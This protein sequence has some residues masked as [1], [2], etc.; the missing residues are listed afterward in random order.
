MGSTEAS[1][2]ECHTGMMW[3]AWMLFM[4]QVSATL[5]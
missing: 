5:M 4:E 3:H 2:Q 1:E